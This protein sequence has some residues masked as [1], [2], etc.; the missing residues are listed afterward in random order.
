M[1]VCACVYIYIYT[2]THTHTHIY[3]YIY[4]YESGTLIMSNLPV[5]N[6][7]EPGGHKI[8]NM[9]NMIFK[10]A[11]AQAHMGPGT[12]GPGPLPPQRNP[13]RKSDL[14]KSTI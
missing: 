7:P 13:H 12:P 14:R 9:I 2:Y 10:I 8:Q 4:I 6:D 11:R 5:K 3:I 1:C